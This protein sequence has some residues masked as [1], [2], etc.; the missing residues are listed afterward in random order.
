MRS[1]SLTGPP[2]SARDTVA[3]DTPAAAAT[4][5]IR[6]VIAEIVSKESA[7]IA[8]ADTATNGRHT[9]E[10]PNIEHNYPLIGGATTHRTL[11]RTM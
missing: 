4:S 5:L 6:T 9:R 7:M 3:T 8:N 2:A 10:F 1:A 11:T